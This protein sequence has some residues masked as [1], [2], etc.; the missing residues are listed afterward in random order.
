MNIIQLIEKKGNNFSLTEEELKFLFQEYQ[1][2]R[3]PDYQMSSL[4]MAIKINGLNEEELFIYTKILLDSGKTIIFN[5][6]ERRV[7][8]HSTGGVGDKVSLLLAP[9]LAANKIN[10]GKLSGRGLGFTGGTIDKLESIPGFNVDLTLE[11]FVS[12]SQEHGISL[13]GATSEFA[14]LDKSIY[15]LRDVTGTVGSLELIA[16]SIMSKKLV[17]NSK[18]IFIDLKCGSAAFFKT[19]EEALKAAKLFKKIGLHFGRK[20]FVMISTMEQPLGNFIGNKLEVWEAIDILRNE[21]KNDAFLLTKEIASY[22]IAEINKVSFE[23]ANKL[24]DK[25]IED[26]SAFNK[27]IEWIKIQGGEIEVFLKQKR[28]NTKYIYPIK[29]SSEGYVS[30]QEVDKLG[31]AVVDLGGGRKQL[32]DKINYNVGIQVLKKTNDYVKKFDEIML[33]YSDKELSTKFL[34]HLK[35]LIKIEQNKVPFEMVIETIVW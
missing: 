25:V 11:E 1:E 22:I 15:A 16:A 35:S 29:T 2:K 17:T 23:E 6:L 34:N 30:F 3:M 7:D 33:V 31:Y 14:P 8:K 20:I 12:N 9:I 4:L 18:Y 5:D 24:V 32:H 28:I 21:T 26:Q 27:F 19:K 10:I 13:I